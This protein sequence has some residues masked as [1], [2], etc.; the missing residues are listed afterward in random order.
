MLDE[1]TLMQKAT[2]E[3]IRIFG[4]GYLRD[5]YRNTCKAYG[6]VDDQTFQLFVG[7]K[8]AADLPDRKPNAKGWV[9]YGKVFVDAVTG[10][11]KET[12]YALE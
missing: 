12:E 8:G 9:V 4:K 1:K 7:I 6:M 3:L 10:E 11:I 2:A 5:N